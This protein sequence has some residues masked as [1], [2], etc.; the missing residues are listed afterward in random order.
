M[1]TVF[2]AHLDFTPDWMLLIASVLYT[3]N[4]IRLLR[5]RSEKRQGFAP[6][7]C[8]ILF[9]GIGGMARG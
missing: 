2:E 6:L 3:L 9:I 7:I 4:G 5:K 8:P 1:T